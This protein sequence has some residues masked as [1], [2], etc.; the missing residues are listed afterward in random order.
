MDS[1]CQYAHGRTQTANN[2]AAR[3]FRHLFVDIPIRNKQH[4]R[5]CYS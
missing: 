1:Y 5:L 3:L 4:I 2:H